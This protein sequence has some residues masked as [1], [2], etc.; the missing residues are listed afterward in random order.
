MFDL[1]HLILVHYQNKKTVVMERS[2]KVTERKGSW[3]YYYRTRLE[4][5][6]PRPLL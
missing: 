4:Y 2:D 3:T 6:N 5:R 1:S